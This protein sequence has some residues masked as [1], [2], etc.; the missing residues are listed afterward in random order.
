MR[1][2]TSKQNGRKRTNYLQPTAAPPERGIGVVPVLT[3]P[4]YGTQVLLTT[5]VTTGL[6]ASEQ[7]ISPPSTV[8]GWS[9]RFSTTFQEY[10]VISVTLEFIAVAINPGV[11]SFFI[12]EG[13]SG[14]GTPTVTEA[15]EIPGRWIN[16][17]NQGA[18]RHMLKWRAKDFTD[19]SWRGISTGYNPFHWYAY[20]D[21]TNFG[22]PTT[23]QNL[24]IVRPRMVI[25]FRGMA[26]T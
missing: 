25:Q 26:S 19:A 21:A 23:A 12:Y 6:I 14:L 18:S 13:S 10:R 15:S 16:N 11:T 4:I 8:S 7:Q 20:T 24:W 3:L 22:S 2:R 9:S 1:G 5:T 17:N